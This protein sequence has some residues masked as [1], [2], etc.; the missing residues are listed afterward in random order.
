MINDYSPM[1][2]N[3]P[4]ENN[5]IKAVN[6]P[7]ILWRSLIARS[8]LF[9]HLVHCAQFSL[10]T[11]CRLM[12]RSSSAHVISTDPAMQHRDILETRSSSEVPAAEQIPQSFPED[13][14]M[15]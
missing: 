2:N 12:V 5:T 6:T 3:S 1:R 7:E 11:D 15:Y 8:Q 4:P 10:V 14:A 9:I 13:P